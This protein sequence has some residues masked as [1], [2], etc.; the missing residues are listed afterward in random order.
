MRSR[1]G[2]LLTASP[3]PATVLL[4]AISSS[5]A[6]ASAPPS[7]MPWGTTAHGRSCLR[8][9]TSSWGLTPDDVSALADGG[10]FAPPPLTPDEIE[11]L[12]REVPKDAP[13]SIR[14]DFP[15]WL[16]PQ[17]E[18]AFGVHAA[19]EG[20]GFPLALPSTSGSTRLRRRGRRCCTRF[21]AS[22][23]RRRRIRR[24]ACVSRRAQARAATRMSRPSP[25][26]AK[27]G[28][29][30]RTKARSSRRCSRAAI[31]SSRSS[32]FAPAPAARRLGLPQS[33]RI[34]ASSMPMMPTACGSGRFSSG[35]KRAG[36][37]NAQV[38]DPGDA[39]SACRA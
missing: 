5:I 6:Y 22:I 3:A 18:R 38:L 24:L 13:V 23:R 12:K 26:T 7:P 17:F 9:L 16:E 21:A 8:T 11:G 37:R 33:W 35:C 10:R 29:R 32:I 15:A 20:M 2:G 36:V 1:I 27:A 4:S 34:P 14:G 19:E 39:G 31:P 28:T 30:F 25:P